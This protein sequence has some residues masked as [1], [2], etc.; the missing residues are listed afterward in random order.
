MSLSHILD[1]FDELGITIGDFV[2]ELL[3][4]GHE[5]PAVE[6]IFG[7][8]EKI[9]EALNSERTQQIIDRWS[10][11]N[12]IKFLQDEMCKLTL[13]E[14]GFHFSART[15]TETKLKDFDV[16]VMS[17]KMQ[18][19]AP[20]LCK[21]FDVLLE[22]NPA[23]SYKR[24]WA[25]RKAEASGLTRQEKRDAGKATDGDI[26]MEDVTSQEND[27]ENVIGE[28]EYWNLFDLQEISLIDDED[29]E[30]EGMEEVVDEQQSK[31]KTIVRSFESMCTPYIDLFLIKLCRNVLSA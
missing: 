26:N 8:L 30:P 23:L 18:S 9:L 12:T 4:S 6:S 1:T 10:C 16:Q 31:L 7:N 25:R 21:L 15:T 14:T 24:N 20:G 27:S 2:L 11:Q 19:L 13:K 3:T 22:A 5:H 29:D 28:R 17:N